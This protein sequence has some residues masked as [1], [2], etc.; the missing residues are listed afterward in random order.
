MRRCARCGDEFPVR[1]T[2][3]RYCGRCATDVARLVT[4]KTI[5]GPAWLRRIQPK[6]Y[7]RQAA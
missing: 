6:D 3:D 2:K 5:D 4:P 7:T 1:T